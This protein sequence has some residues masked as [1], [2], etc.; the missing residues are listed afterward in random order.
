MS[1]GKSRANTK[2]ARPTTVAADLASLTPEKRKVI[3][4]PR[5]FGAGAN[6]W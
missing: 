1:A 4:E 5:A 2:A 3:E 6:Q